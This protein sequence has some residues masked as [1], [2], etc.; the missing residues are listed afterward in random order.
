MKVY[1]LCCGQGHGFEG[2]FGSEAE[3]LD[4]Q[5]RGLVCC[6]F[7]ETSEV[8]RRPS[9]PRLNLARGREL[10]PV[11][12]AG[13]TLPAGNLTGDGAQNPAADAARAQ[14]PGTVTP[15]SAWLQAV[16]RVMASTEDVGPRFTDLAKRMH[17]G[18]LP[19]KAIRG[20]AT[21]EQ[22]R[23]LRE[24]GIDVVS[25]PVPPALQGPLQ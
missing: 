21:A 7:C 11:H 16:R 24:E 23:E 9:A 6:P 22:A 19:E 18:E 25:I 17:Y 4:Q 10:V 2:W 12:G 5:S 3:F 14:A 1:N 13:R 15:E 8:E 20:Q